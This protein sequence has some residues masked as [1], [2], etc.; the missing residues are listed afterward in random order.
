M[1]K[2]LACVI[3]LIITFSGL[4]GC[5]EKG[6]LRDGEI[7]KSGSELRYYCSDQ[8]LSDFLND[9]YSRH[10]RNGEDAIGLVKMGNGET[11]QKL[12]ETDSIVWFDSSINGLG[13]YDAMEN[14]RTWITNIT[15][16]RK[17][18][19]YSTINV[20][21]DENP[22]PWM[23]YGW[24]FPGYS[25]VDNNGAPKNSVYGENFKSGAGG[26]TVNGETGKIN[27]NDNS[28]KYLDFSFYGKENQALI[29][30]SPEIGKNGEG[31]DTTL[32]SNV[33][34]LELLIEDL[35][36]DS[37]FDS[38]A[39]E[40]FFIEWRTTESKSAFGE[41]FWFEVSQKDFACA[42]ENFTNYTMFRAYFP[43]YLNTNWDGKH[44]TD[45]RVVFKPSEDKRLNLNG[46]MN[47]VYFICDNSNTVNIGNFIE[48][49]EKYVCFNNDIDLLKQQ[50]TRA[51]KAMLYELYVL[52]GKQ[53]YTDLSFY[54][55]RAL[56]DGTG[57]INQNGFWDMYPTG[58]RNAESDIYFYAALKSLARLEKYLQDAGV[59]V[60]DEAAIE[61]P[62]KG[63]NCS[64]K[65]VYNETVES[66][67]KLSEK[68]KENIRKNVADG[69]F[70]NPDTGRF[71]W[72][73]YD[74][75]PRTG[76][77]GGAMDYGH[78]ELNL[79]A[80]YYGIAT[81]SQATSV[82]SW[83]DGE[84]IVD[85]DTSCG[86]DIYIYEMAP[87]STTRQNNVDHN[88]MW[89][90][91][92]GLKKWANNCEN[93][94]CCLFVAFYDLMARACFKGADNAYER[95]KKV[96]SWYNDVA[97][98][99]GEGT[100]FY[101]EYYE[102]KYSNDETGNPGQWELVGRGVNNSVGII[103]EFYES[104]TL[105]ATVPYMFFGLSAVQYN[106]IGIKPNLPE[107]ISW[108][109]LEN[110]MYAN[111]KYDCYIENNRVIISGVRGETNG[112]RVSVSI[113]KPSDKF[114]VKINGKKTADYTESGEYVIVNVPLEKTEITVS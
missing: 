90:Q 77:E 86:D 48:T 42:P 99:G 97:S 28:T 7:I 9:F 51:R 64:M 50:I 83:I 1:K 103:G 19:I 58:I 17:G 46:K 45:I 78:T 16:D 47:Y 21:H 60:S 34:E 61:L 88:P 10:I 67:D 22:R 100:A 37:D 12:W 24:P 57:Y 84:R 114:T 95:L 23:G 36:Y 87:R 69:G 33:I 52:N 29:L 43:M 5:A 54:K 25:A 107:K 18:Y 102:E 20:T 4:V 85:G 65:V 81:E 74:E 112:E 113:K 104:A 76:L 105:Y 80:I 39:I 11:Y 63:E 49:L 101:D 109:A 93:G 2:L 44:V 91:T 110:L 59:S 96:E 62:V 30:Q 106:T 13:T 70:W 35:N 94:G 3:S 38:S 89:E 56:T 32:W 79:M 82:F 75:N 111:V 8:T 66:L 72:A 73:I 71:A 108:F 15:Q 6:I 92:G 14:I 40:D 98:Y 41:D 68:V 55:G 53:G 31:I 26:W 27:I